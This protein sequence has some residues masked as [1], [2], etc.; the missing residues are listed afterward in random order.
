MVAAAAM[1]LQDEPLRRAHPSCLCMATTR[2]AME[3]PLLQTA[4]NPS[5]SRGKGLPLHAGDTA[6]EPIIPSRVTSMVLS[7]LQAA[8]PGAAACQLFKIHL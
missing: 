5:L 2:Q 6:V 1:E 7:H 8:P 4:S 3:D